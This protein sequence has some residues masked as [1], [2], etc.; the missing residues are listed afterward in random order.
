MRDD[1][2]VF[3]TEC[4]RK[5]ASAVIMR[6]KSLGASDWQGVLK[7]RPELGLAPLEDD[8]VAEQAAH[9]GV[10]QSGVLGTQ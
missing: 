8:R 1:M 9:V 2:T 7:F 6:L 10:R 4:C 3:F 5:F